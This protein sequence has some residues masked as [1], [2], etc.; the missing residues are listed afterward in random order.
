MGGPSWI[1]SE[2]Y[3]IDAMEVDSL[4]G[5]TVQRLLADR[6]RLTLHHETK[7]LPVYALVIEKNG[8]KLQEAKPG[9]GISSDGR[10]YARPG[11]I[12]WGEEQRPGSTR[13]ELTGY[14]TPITL[15]VDA[16]SIRLGRPVLDQTGLK[17]NYKFNLH[18]T[19]DAS[20]PSIFTA[21]HEQLG[22]DL[23]STK[24]PVEILV[25]DHIE[26]PSEN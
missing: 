25:I 19:P 18:W 12:F 21:L 1:E 8:P 23:E 17:G 16:L 5:A 9:V 15:L 10:G 2:K 22:L 3:D 20:G 26:K 14:A 4:A 6:F 13:R 7:E 24:G 11:G